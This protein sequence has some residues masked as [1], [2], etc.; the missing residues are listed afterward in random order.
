[1]GACV[2][3]GA[4][5]VIASDIAVNAAATSLIMT[6]IASTVTHTAQLL[7]LAMLLLLLCRQ[8]VMGACVCDGAHVVIASDIAVNA[9]ATS[10]IMTRIA[11]TVI[12]TVQRLLLALRL[13]L[14]CRQHVMG[15]C[16]CDG[17]H[18]VIASNIVL[19]VAAT[20]TNIRPAPTLP[21]HHNLRVS[22]FAST[23]PQSAMPV[24]SK[25]CQP[26]ITSSS[27]AAASRSRL[28]R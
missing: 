26:I 23:N 6:R 14:L 11:S 17:A 21:A 12:H 20:R 3:D 15:A 7:L 5:V 25:A 13:L 16:V 28:F 22:A 27:R 24:S 9:A 10:L 18:V 4:H 19:Y 8:H 2:C 1:M